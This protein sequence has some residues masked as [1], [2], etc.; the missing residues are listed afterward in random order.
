MVHPSMKTEAPPTTPSVAGSPFDDKEIADVIITTSDK[1]DFYILR[2]ILIIASPFFRTMFTLVQPKKTPEDA[3]ELDRVPVSE[4]SNTFDHLM[5]LCYPVKAPV[6]D[7]IPLLGRVLEA[8]MKYEIEVARY[9]AI[10]S[11]R[12]YVNK[13]PLEVYAVACRAGISDEA[14]LAAGIWKRKCKPPSY[15]DTHASFDDTIPGASYIRDMAA[16]S[17][18][19]YYRL[20]Q[21]I[22]ADALHAYSFYP[23]TTSPQVTIPPSNEEYADADV[24]L[25]ST[26]QDSFHANSAVLRAASAQ[27]LLEDTSPLLS[28]SD[29]VIVRR[30]QTK[31]DR[32]TLGAIVDFAYP[33]R[34]SAKATDLHHIKALIEGALKYQIQDIIDVGKRLLF[35][36]Y[37]THSLS[38][39][40]F[41]C[42]KG[43]D[44]EVE[45]AARS[46]VSRGIT[47][48]YVEEMEDAPAAAYYHL[49]KL[50]HRYLTDMARV[51][52]DTI[53][54]D[55]LQSSST[56]LFASLPYLDRVFNEVQHTARTSAFGGTHRCFLCR[57]THHALL[58]ASAGCTCATGKLVKALDI[59]GAQQKKEALKGELKRVVSKV[60]PMFITTFA[61]Q[62]THSHLLPRLL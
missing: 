8:A 50:Q 38:V 10:A 44:T 21:H 43:W 14:G 36:L 31:L 3:Q 24:V 27:P 42:S 20:I 26:G 4:D 28:E 53:P 29:P 23:P 45:D 56:S 47:G 41:A 17:A 25:L 37:D 32:V 11:L 30:V 18:G 15:S 58:Q 35:N 62:S 13:Q 61:S 57:E 59:S 46:A 40:M 5:R 6:N 48:V 7:S 39:Y 54:A 49:L 33:L 2:G 60:R 1:V 34:S 9:A 16:I 22:R 55:V 19:Q 51:F 52:R 12:R